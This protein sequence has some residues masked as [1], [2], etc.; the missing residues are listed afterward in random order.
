MKLFFKTLTIFGVFLVSLSSFALANPASV[1]CV[2]TGNKLVLIQN[3]GICVFPDGSYCEEW[4][5]FR[6]KCA[7]GQN[8]FPGGKFDPTHKQQYC[9]SKVNNVTVVE[10]CNPTTGQ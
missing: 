7:K 10:M 5:L 6:G 1:N 9:I 4:A 2:N 3:T 8:L